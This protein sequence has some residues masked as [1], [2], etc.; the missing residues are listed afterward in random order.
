MVWFWMRSGYFFF[1]SFGRMRE[2]F[3]DFFLVLSEFFF[4]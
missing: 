4:G 1:F 2:R 3:H